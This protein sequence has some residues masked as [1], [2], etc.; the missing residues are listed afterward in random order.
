MNKKTSYY[1]LGKKLFGI[2]L[3]LALLVSVMH[4]PVIKTKAA[5]SVP[6]VNYTTHCQSYG[7]L[8]QVSN[9]KNSGT[10]GV[11]KRLEAI[12]ISLD[13]KGINAKD[14][15]AM[16]GGIRYRV[17]AQSYG[18]MNWVTGD[19]NGASTTSMIQKQQYAGTIGKSK[20]LEAIRIELT[21]KVAEE[22]DILYRV[23]CQSYGWMPWVKN[24]E[25]AGTTGQGKRLE[26]IEIKLVRKPETVDASLTYS[27]HCQ[28]YG[29]MN[30]VADGSIAGT[31]GE[32]KRL[33]ALKINFQCSGMTGGIQYSTHVQS[34]GWMNP[35]V[36]G[37]VSG[38]TGQSKRMEAVKIALTGDISAYYDVYYRVHCQSNGWLDW[39][40]NGEPAGTEGFGRR[41]EAIQIK[42]VKKGQAA[43]G[44]TSK[45]YV[46]YVYV[47]PTKDT[48]VIKV[49]K[50]ACCVTVYKDGN[51]IKAFPCS[52]GEA[53]PTGTFH[54][55]QKWRWRE[56][57]GGVKGQYTSQITGDF[58]FHSVLYN[59]TNIRTLQPSS[60]NNLGKMVSHGCVRL[61]V[62]D[63]KWIYDNCPEG[64]TV[65]IYNS[66]DP[67]PLGKPMYDPI[68]KSQTWDPTDPGL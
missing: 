7:W 42:L 45:P 22:Y 32:K 53:T 27:V 36:G 46:K 63:A 21:G 33:E 15:T 3:A 19:N 54:I 31:T 52:P 1:L 66:S 59:E 58:L 29:W 65:I 13:M 55:P 47:P 28:S 64:T 60:F 61:A 24:G 16:T 56:L 4:I 50:Q 2:V 6:T 9:G 5:S 11:G 20:R 49:N 25:L 48:Y 34:Y 10:T 17:H 38:V 68:P 26:S 43:P 67:G 40:K 41:M 57:M 12:T 62:G 8:N 14:G 35:V 30:T 44:S 23:H 18:W 51:A 39:A 37:Q